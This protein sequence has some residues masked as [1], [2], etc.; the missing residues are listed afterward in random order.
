MLLRKGA[1]APGTTQ[2]FAT[3]GSSQVSAAFGT[4]TS[5]IRVAVQADTY[6]ALGGSSVTATNSS[7]IIPAGQIEFIAVGTGTGFTYIAFLQ[8]TTSGYISITELA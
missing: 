8:V 6:I 7:M 3:S 5:V 2:N 4:S 1:Y